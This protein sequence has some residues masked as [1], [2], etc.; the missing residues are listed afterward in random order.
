M[1]YI[2]D[3]VLNFNDCYYEFYEW[4]NKDKIINVKKIP[5][6]RINDIDYLSFKYNKVSII[7]S[8]VKTILF[9]KSNQNY[10]IYLVTNTLEVM[11]IMLDKSGNIIK[12]SSLLLEE[13]DEVLQLLIEYDPKDDVTVEDDEIQDVEF[14]EITET[15]ESNIE[16]QVSLL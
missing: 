9:N 11:A 15:D 13:A 2:Y 14:N 5:V 16:G 1:E 3:I 8:F 4:N 7:K 10:N 12:R 6:Y